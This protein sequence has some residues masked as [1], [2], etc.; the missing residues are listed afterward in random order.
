MLRVFVRAGMVLGLTAMVLAVAGSVL[1]GPAARSDAAQPIGREQ[2]PQVASATSNFTIAVA[3][4]VAN[5]LT[6]PDGIDI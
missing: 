1:A 3:A 5:G 4:V 2:I 6:Q